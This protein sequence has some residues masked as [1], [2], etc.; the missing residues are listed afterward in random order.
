MKRVLDR[1]RAVFRGC[2][3]SPQTYYTTAARCSHHAQTHNLRNVGKPVDAGGQPPIAC[4]SLQVGSEGDCQIGKG[5]A[6][7]DERQGAK[8]DKEPATSAD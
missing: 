3:S 8:Q 2:H 1:V 4:N 7:R 6:Q 5:K